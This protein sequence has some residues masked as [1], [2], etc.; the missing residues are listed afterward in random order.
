[1]GPP[2]IQT[3]LFASETACIRN[4]HSLTSQTLL[5]RFPCRSR[6]F[7]AVEDTRVGKSAYS[8]PAHGSLRRMHEHFPKKAA[9][10]NSAVLLAAKKEIVVKCWS[11][12]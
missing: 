5:I 2:W 6:W 3:T 11:A 8:T 1:M 4:C 7:S 12:A 10:P 9:C